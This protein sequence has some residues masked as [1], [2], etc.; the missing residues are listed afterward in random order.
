MVVD[1]LCLH[2]KELK[3]KK[4]FVKDWRLKEKLS[5][6]KNGLLLFEGKKVLEKGEIKSA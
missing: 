1:F 5:I 2:K 3:R 6:D 4:L